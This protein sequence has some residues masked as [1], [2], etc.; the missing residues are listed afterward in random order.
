LL[1]GK[2]RRVWGDQAY[3]GQKAA[4]RAGAP[5]EKDFTIQ[6]YRLG[7]RIDESVKASNRRKSSVRAKV[8]H[9]FGMIKRVFGFHSVARMC[10]EQCTLNM[11]PE[12]GEG[13]SPLYPQHFSLRY[14]RHGWLAP[15]YGS[16]CGGNP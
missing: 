1:H 7:K 3:R 11:L 15:F 4:I 16:V 8:E 9:A 12:S 6:R 5:R 13:M 2:K 10:R 14:D